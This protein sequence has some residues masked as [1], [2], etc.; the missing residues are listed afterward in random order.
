M[1][2]R[3][4]APGTPGVPGRGTVYGSPTGQLPQVPTG[5]AVP[6][7]PGP[8]AGSSANG[9]GGAAAA[10]LPEPAL[11]VAPGET[12]S[13]TVTI[14]N[15]G[16]QVEEFTLTVLGPTTGWTTLEP[17][18]LSVYPGERTDCTVRFAPP[19]TSAPL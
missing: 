16:S 11:S 1:P 5:P 14:H 17:P 8:P 4:A 12:A 19:R 7:A 13:T 3:P 15:G 2:I 6:G 18:T 9:Q 10:V